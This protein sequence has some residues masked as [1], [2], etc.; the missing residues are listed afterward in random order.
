VGIGLY[1]AALL[2]I[3]V[4]STQPDILIYRSLARSGSSWRDL[5][6]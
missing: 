1:T 6:L 5:V 4:T 2:K 3:G